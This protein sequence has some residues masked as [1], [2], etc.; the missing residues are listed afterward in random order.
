MLN[1]LHEVQDHILKSGQTAVGANRITTAVT[2]LEA[3]LGVIDH[4]EG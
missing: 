1:K 3:G 2:L 4:E